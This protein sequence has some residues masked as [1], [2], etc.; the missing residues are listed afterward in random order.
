M[1]SAMSKPNLLKKQESSTSKVSHII[2]LGDIEPFDVVVLTREDT[3][4]FGLEKDTALEIK[5]LRGSNI[6]ML[7]SIGEPVSYM[8]Y[9][10]NVLQK[11]HR[12]SPIEKEVS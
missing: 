4:L 8:M 3:N 6:R 11:L 1:A 2:K 12:I 9:F 7:C 10:H 5:N